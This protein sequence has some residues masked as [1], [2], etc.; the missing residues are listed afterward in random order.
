M[1][2]NDSYDPCPPERTSK[3]RFWDAL[4]CLPPCRWSCIDGVDSFHIS[5][6]LRGDTAAWYAQLGDSY[7]R[8][9]DS[10]KQSKTEIAKMIRNADAELPPLGG[11]EELG[12]AAA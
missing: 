10:R 4:E 8:W 7:F 1:P 5:E 2:M 3:E 6:L 12:R 11:V 9:Q